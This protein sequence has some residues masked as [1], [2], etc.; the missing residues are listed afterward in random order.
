MWVQKGNNKAINLDNITMVTLTEEDF[1]VNFYRGDNTLYTNLVFETLEDAQ[2]AFQA[3]A[4]A[5]RNSWP[6]VDL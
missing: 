2:F 3:I 1:S 5:L 6:L 4:D